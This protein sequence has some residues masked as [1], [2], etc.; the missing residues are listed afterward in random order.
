MNRRFGVIHAEARAIHS[1]RHAMRGCGNNRNKKKAAYLP[2][3]TTWQGGQQGS[4]GAL[5]VPPFRLAGAA[6]LGS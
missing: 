4:M 2:F 1:A 6:F 5:H 3:L